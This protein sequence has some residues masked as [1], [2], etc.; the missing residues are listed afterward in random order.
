M[1]TPWTA[2]CVQMSPAPIRTATDR[3]SAAEVISKSIDEGERSVQ[4]A[5][6]RDARDLFLFPEFVFSGGSGPNLIGV[7]D[8][9]GPEIEKVQK[10][11]QKYRVFIASNFYT[12]SPMFPGRYM[13]TSLLMNRSGEI[14]LTSYRLHTYHSTS[15]HDFWQRF[16]D[17]V[18]IEGAFPVAKTEL[19]NISIL[20]SMEILFPEVPRMFVLRGAEVL[21]HTTSEMIVDRSV[22]RTRATENLAFVVSCNAAGLRGPDPY[23][24]VGS[25]IVNFRGQVIAELDQGVSGQCTAVID[26]EGLR[27]R[28]ANIDL[29]Y[30]PYGANYLSRMRVEMFRDIYNSIS[31]YPPDTYVEGT[32]YDRAISPELLVEN[33]K[34]GRRN[35]AKSG[36]LP[37]DYAEGLEA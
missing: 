18:G 34:L 20:P 8:M 12:R 25:L 22:K 21:L 33:L 36:M 4:L 14:I 1:I 32:V 10:I 35:M 11:A 27:R 16:L 5:V 2:T 31:L 3:K 30:P 6:G 13:N 17:K 26:V 24:Q 19:G 7:V 9:P 29:G 28:R 23:M 37:T 15:P